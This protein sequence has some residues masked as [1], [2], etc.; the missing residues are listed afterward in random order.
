M[1]LLK[2]RDRLDKIED[3]DS[4]YQALE[5]TSS[6]IVG[7]GWA[8]III[9]ALFASSVG[10][11]SLIANLSIFQKTE[12]ELLKI[13]ISILA[14][15]ISW[16]PSTLMGVFI[17]AYGQMLKLMLDIRNDVDVTRQ[18]IR[19]ISLHFARTIEKPDDII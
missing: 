18:Y 10:A 3:Q 15:L 16:A 12:N 6:V 2:L 13:L 8:V 11:F 5:F 19:A 1:S 4:P 14:L 7:L 9:G 17:I